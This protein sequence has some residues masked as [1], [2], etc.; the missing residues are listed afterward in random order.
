MHVHGTSD[1]LVAYT[2]AAGGPVGPYPAI[3]ALVGGWRAADGCDANPRVRVAGAV[4]REVARSCSEGTGVVL[5]TVAKGVHEW[6]G[7]MR[8]QTP[9][10]T[11][12]TTRELWAFFAAHP[13]R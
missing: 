9:A 4:R 8:A 6:P 7:G 5:V 1:P 11:F 3:P 12:D 13:R 2:G 10:S